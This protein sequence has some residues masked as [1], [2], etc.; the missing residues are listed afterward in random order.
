[1][2]EPA[3]ILIRWLDI[4]AAVAASLPVAEGNGADEADD[5]EESN[6][7]SIQAVSEHWHVPGDTLRF[8]CRSE[9]GLGLRTGNV[10]RVSVP[11]LK[12]RLA[13]RGG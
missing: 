8:W 13:R 6:L 5:F 1:V 4:K 2:P 7:A 10:W 11:A 9:P 3:A 12:R